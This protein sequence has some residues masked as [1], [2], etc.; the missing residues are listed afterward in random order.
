MNTQPVLTVQFCDDIRQ[1]VGNK[2]SLMGCY[3]GELLVEALPAILPKLCAQV[4]LITLKEQP[5]ERCV[6][7]ALLNGEQIGELELP[8][9]QLNAAIRLGDADSTRIAYA[10][11]MSFAPF[12]FEKEGVFQLEA[13]TDSGLIKGGRLRLMLAETHRR[14]LEESSK[15]S[16]Q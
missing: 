6:L 13:E 7:R 1:E 15:N 4:K 5:I 8:V 2:F 12:V 16:A 10:A 11:I 14:A 9:V 3:G